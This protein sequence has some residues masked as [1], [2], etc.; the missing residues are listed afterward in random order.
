M[1]TGD[2]KYLVTPEMI[3]AGANEVLAVVYDTVSGR[4]AALECYLAMR[5]L[6][7]TDQLTYE[8][9]P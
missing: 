3:E 1:A 4:E 8:N 6:E 7:P 2:Q 5:A 9:G